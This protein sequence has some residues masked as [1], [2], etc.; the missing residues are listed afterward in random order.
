MKPAFKVGDLIHAPGNAFLVERVLGAGGM[1][2]VYWV[3]DKELDEPRVLKV[4]HP[5]HARDRPELVDRFLREARAMTK[6]K[7]P[8]I[9]RVI[10]L[11]RLLDA[12]RSPAFTMEA[13][14]GFSVADAIGRG[15]E[16]PHRALQ[17]YYQTL[18]GLDAMHQ[19]GLVHRDIKPA[20]LLLHNEEGREELLVKI[21]D[22]GVV[23]I[24]VD[25][26]D[27]E[28]FIGTFAYASDR[29][30]SGKLA[31]PADDVWAA[32]MVLYELLTGCHPFQEFGLGKDGALARIGKTPRTLRDHG[33][34]LPDLD[35]LLSKALDPD[36]AA[37]FQDAF[38]AMKVVKKLHKSYLERFQ[39]PPKAA[40]TTEDR[41]VQPNA[42]PITQALLSP[43]RPDAPPPDWLAEFR[44]DFA[45]GRVAVNAIASS[46]D[47]HGPTT[48]G[49]NARAVR[50]TIDERLERPAGVTMPSAARAGEPA[51]S[52]AAPAVARLAPTEQPSVSPVPAIVSEIVYV[53]ASSPMTD[54]PG[55]AAAKD[56]AAE[57]KAG[58]RLLL[59]VRGDENVRSASF[60][61]DEFPVVLGRE[62]PAD[63]VL[64]HRGVSGRHA[65][66][67]VDGDG[68]TIVDDAS[69]NGTH[70]EG[71][72]GPEPIEANTPHALVDGGVFYV[73]PIEIRTF[74]SARR[75]R[76]ELA[77]LAQRVLEP[78]NR[79]RMRPPKPKRSAKVLPIAAVLLVVASLVGVIA[80]RSAHRAQAN[81]ATEMGGSP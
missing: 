50:A 3:I 45:A 51:P 66:I 55:K 16:A 43:T 32:S 27:Y 18:A 24:V 42:S 48:P 26:R 21:L 34:D 46:I 11:L 22:F 13:L 77:K 33:L 1:G 59:L 10:A 64:A 41:A 12:H 44:D 9:V 4:L 63:L 53:P 47:V 28:G 75:S 71:A 70:F 49:P 78:S 52:P 65:T 40:T 67:S 19:R 38:S 62:K 14:Q 31:E 76:E 17:I 23:R 5:D 35:E 81:R 74:F 61:I 58:P 6:I 60:L 80:W 20:N 29:Q 73:G 56:G 57:K 68:Y 30:L 39:G 36:P 69:T 37:R 2:A 7:H 79:G 72:D 8:N 25:E 15:V 54:L